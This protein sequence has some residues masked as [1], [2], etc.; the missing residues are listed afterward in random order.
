MRKEETTYKKLDLLNQT[1]K[2]SL[3]DIQIEDKLKAFS[4]QARKLGSLEPR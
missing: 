4:R 2:V 3:S 1:E